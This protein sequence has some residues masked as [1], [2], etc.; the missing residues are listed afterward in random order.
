MRVARV[1]FVALMAFAVCFSSEAKKQKGLKDV[2]RKYFTVGVAVNRRNVSRPEQMEML[3]REFNSITAENDMKAISVHPALGVWRWEGADRIANFC[4]EHKIPC[5]G[6]NLVWHNQF[7]D[8]MFEDG[9]GNPVSKEVFYARLREHIHTVVRRYKDIIYCWDVVNEA[10]ADGPRKDGPL[11]ERDFRQSRL[12]KLCGDEFIAKA[13]EFAHEADPDALLFYNDYN[14]ADPVK[15]E[16]IYLMV[17]QMQ[18]K[19]VPIHGIGM[20]GHYN[21]HG[22]SE[23]HIEAAIAKYEKL[24]KHIHFTEVDVRASKEMG[25]QLEFDRNNVELTAKADS[26]LTA[27]YVSLFNVFRRHHKV[28]DNVTFWNLSDRDS[29]LGEKNYPLLFNSAYQ[30]KPA[31]DA[32]VNFK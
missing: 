24:V 14:E 32:V 1:L 2:F 28:I 7:C 4:R 17:K 21:V 5:R 23:Q 20:Q 22:P 18:E 30:R 13:F 10:M 26:M 12:Y 19:G 6:H 11:N 3:C 25:G 29:W 27:K 9:Q 15:S 16:R 31:Y 8:W